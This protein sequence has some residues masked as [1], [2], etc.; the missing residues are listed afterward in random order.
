M[1]VAHFMFTMVTISRVEGDL[2]LVVRV[3]NQLV[4]EN[5]DV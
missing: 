2:L 3:V 4:P 1:L 5:G